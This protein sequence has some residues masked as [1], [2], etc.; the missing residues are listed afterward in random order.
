MIRKNAH[1][2]DA[3]SPVIGVI[4]M[5]AVTVILAAVIASF[6]LGM[7]NGIQKTKIVDVTISRDGPSAITAT[8]H[9]GQDASSLTGVYFM[10]NGANASVRAS[11]ITKSGGVAGEI[12]LPSSGQILPIGGSGTVNATPN[13]HLIGIGQ[14]TDG[15]SQV[16]IDTII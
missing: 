4:L 14:F 1:N 16:L 2:S 5:V 9:G 13:S 6:V 12:L 15:T 11:G 7:A 8:N 10:V 3:V